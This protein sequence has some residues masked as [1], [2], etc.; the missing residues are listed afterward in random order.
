MLLRMLVKMRAMENN[1]SFLGVMQLVS[2][3]C[4]TPMTV[5]FGLRECIQY[6]YLI[7]SR[8]YTVVVYASV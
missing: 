3:M 5:I 1:N 6:M 7:S 2:S 4:A 8:V